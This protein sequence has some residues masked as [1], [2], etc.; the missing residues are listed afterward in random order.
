MR[1]FSTPNASSSTLTMGTKQ[2]VV[3]EAFDTTLWEAPSNVS[4]LTPTTKVAS[5]P[6]DGADTTTNGAPPSRWRAAL[7]RLVKIP[8]DST[9]TSTPRSPHGSSL[10]SRTASTLSVSPSTLMPS[11]VGSMS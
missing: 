1:P 5:A 11:S 7:S 6:E 9:T 2:L 3:H 4:S 8:V 10:G